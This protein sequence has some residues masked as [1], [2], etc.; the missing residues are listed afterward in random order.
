VTSKVAADIAPKPEN[1]YEHGLGAGRA[2]PGIPLYV[3][4]LENEL[5]PVPGYGRTTPGPAATTVRG[6]SWAI[7]SDFRVVGVDEGGTFSAAD[8]P[9]DRGTLPVPSPLITDF[10]SGGPIPVDAGRDTNLKRP[11][12]H[13]HPG[14]EGDAL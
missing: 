2:P 1:F 6:D 14:E 4:K 5:Q 10:T 11:T 9:V 7:G 12:S 3:T 13:K 8:K